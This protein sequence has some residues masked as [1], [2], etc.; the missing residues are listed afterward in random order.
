MKN[1]KIYIFD[2]KVPFL[3][4]KSNLKVTLGASPQIGALSVKSEILVTL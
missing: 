3:T 1:N 2:P 4:L